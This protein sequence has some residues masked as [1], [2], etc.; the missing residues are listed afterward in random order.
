MCVCCVLVRVCELGA[1]GCVR[2]VGYPQE[3][4]KSPPQFS[5]LGIQLSLAIT[6]YSSTVYI[7]IAM[8]GPAL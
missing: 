4:F 8:G 6:Q 7:G 3:I 5:R 1:L 2:R